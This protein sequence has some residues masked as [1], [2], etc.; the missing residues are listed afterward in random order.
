MKNMTRSSSD[1][2]FTPA[3]KAI[4]TEKGSR[5]SYARMEARGGWKTTVTEDLV[6]FLSGLDMFYPGHRQSRGAALH[7][8]SRRPC[9]ISQGAG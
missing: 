8:V 9:W 4:Q 7:S 5:A 3:V 6:S 2:A 1:V